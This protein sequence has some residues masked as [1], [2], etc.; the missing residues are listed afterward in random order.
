M[1]AE[2]RYAILKKKLVVNATLMT[3]HTQDDQTETVLL[4]LLRGA[5]PKGLAAMKIISI[6]WSRIFMAS[7][8]KFNSSA[9]T[10]LRGSTSI[11]LDR[12]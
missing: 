7:I 10:S 9:I 6:L 4:Q 11:N 3:A 12:R 2:A 5:G 8:V 1:G